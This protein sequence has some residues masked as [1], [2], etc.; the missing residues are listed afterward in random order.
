[1]KIDLRKSR[2]I[3]AP[4]TFLE[5]KVS[6]NEI[7]EEELIAET[8]RRRH[9]NAQPGSESSAPTPEAEAIKQGKKASNNLAWL[10]ILLIVVVAGSAYY[11]NQNEMLKPAVD[12]V[13]SYW[14]RTLGYEIENDINLM[15]DD[16][17]TIL[18]EDALL[19]E[20]Q[21]NQLMPV[22]D[23]I[24]A[25]ADSIA[26]LPL[27]SLILDQ[28]AAQPIYDT[29][30]D[31]TEV[32]EIPIKLSDDDI[33][34]IN[35]R[36][37]LLMVTEIIGGL[38]D[39]SVGTHLFLKRDALRMDASIGGPWIEQMKNTMD[40]FVLGSFNA[41]ENPGEIKISS[42]YEIIMSAE[43]DFQ[44]QI[45]DGM[46]LLDVLAQPFADY[47]DE[48]VIDIAGGI[49]DNPATFTFRGS[50]QE[51]QYI[52]SSWAET[53]SNFLLRSIDLK[54]QKENILLSFDVLFFN[55]TP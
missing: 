28:S 42:K 30:S 18:A 52:L 37:L 8:L 48:I 35:N 36:S 50:K 45:L 14:M 16:D 41:A 44:P 51:I 40:K 55:Y 53:R 38:P 39:Q 23:D 21:F 54:F 2:G 13:K 11:L 7:S 34:I 3:L 31:Y 6:E 47:L 12:I 24:A 32:S 20:E 19:S 27:D 22:T 49:N 46:R 10:I 29:V 5:D 26:A 43:Q 4:I 17:E 25:L 1:M 15:V 33:R 9:G